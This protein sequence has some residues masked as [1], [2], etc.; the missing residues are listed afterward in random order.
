MSQCSFILAFGPSL[1]T[2]K[3]GAPL[4]T[5]SEA[6]DLVEPVT[7][8]FADKERVLSPLKILPIAMEEMIFKPDLLLGLERE[9]RQLAR[10]SRVALLMVEGHRDQMAEQ[11]FARVIGLRACEEKC[12]GGVC[13]R[14]GAEE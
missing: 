7:S 8:N 12:L 11:Y 3:N 9:E 5:T 10:P 6:G 4:A 2:L 14:H 13:P 1:D